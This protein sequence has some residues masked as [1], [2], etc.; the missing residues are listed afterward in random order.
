MI[1]L[2]KILLCNYPYYIL[3]IVALTITFYRINLKYTSTYS[4]NDKNFTG[5][6]TNIKI[7]GDLLSFYLKDKNKELI[8]ASYYFKSLKEKNKY[9]DYFKLGDKLKIKGEFSEIEKSTTKNTF[10]YYEYSKRKG[11]FYNM[12]INSIINW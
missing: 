11:M 7:E 9:K 5:I 3:L 1:K 4:N 12:T 10:D 6:I 8:Q 2:R